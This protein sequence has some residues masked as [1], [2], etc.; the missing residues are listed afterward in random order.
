M[1]SFILS[2][3]TVQANTLKAVP[4][5]KINP[6]QCVAL[7]QGQKCYVTVKLNWRV[8]TAGNYCL[9]SS[10]GTD[11]LK[12]WT[13]Q[14]K[15]EF[16]QEFMAKTNILLSLKQKNSQVTLVDAEVKMAWVHKKKGKPRMSWRMF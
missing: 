1:M 4:V 10:Q 16:K 9:F 13:Q 3:L 8:A 5:L 15:G 7:L 2:S 11:A 14:S 6:E 12:C